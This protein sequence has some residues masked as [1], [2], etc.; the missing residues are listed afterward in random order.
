MKKLCLSGIFKKC[1]EPTPHPI[2]HHQEVVSCSDDQDGVAN[3]EQYLDLPSRP[4][5]KLMMETVCKELT[6]YDQP[7]C[8]E[9]PV[10]RQISVSTQMSS[11]LMKSPA[12]WG[13]LLT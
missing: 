12:V 7:V 1:L 6:G 8:Y 4:K 9:K 11:S 3:E 10:A 13:V 5:R 2:I